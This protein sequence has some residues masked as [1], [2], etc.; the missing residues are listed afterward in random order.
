MKGVNDVVDQFLRQV[1]LGGLG[2]LDDLELGSEAEAAYRRRSG[3]RTDPAKLK[4]IPT[5]TV[6]GDKARIA[7][8]MERSPACTSPLPVLRYTRP[9]VSIT[10]TNL[11]D[12]IVTTLVFNGL[13]ST[14]VI[15][16]TRLA[17]GD[18]ITNSASSRVSS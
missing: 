4:G 17:A 3:L 2:E 11:D 8:L 1:H 16:S 12:A 7:N 9:S 14:G 6:F 5:P 18:S 10:K 13:T 15:S